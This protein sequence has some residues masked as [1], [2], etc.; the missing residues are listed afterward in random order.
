MGDSILIV[1]IGAII[2]FVIAHCIATDFYEIAKKKGHFEKKYYWWTFLCGLV[3]YLMVVALPDNS[4]KEE[5]NDDE[6]PEI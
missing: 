4:D 2:Y 3:G 5:I 6:L 1:L